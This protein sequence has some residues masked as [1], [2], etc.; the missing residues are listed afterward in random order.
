MLWR[1]RQIKQHSL[2][3][4]MKTNS[5]LSRYQSLKAC[6]IFF[7]DLKSWKF[8]LLNFINSFSGYKNY[9]ALPTNQGSSFTQTWLSAPVHRSNLKRKRTRTPWY[10]FRLSLRR[11]RLE[12]N[13]ERL[14]KS[15]CSGFLCVAHWLACFTITR[16][17]NLKHDEGFFFFFFLQ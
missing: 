14:T 2:K 6:C 11:L 9:A 12:E 5:R 13:P 10:T 1:P 16:K 15:F 3:P 17:C 8:P 4:S 7:C